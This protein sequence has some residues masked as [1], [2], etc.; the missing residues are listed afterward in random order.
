M[1]QYLSLNSLMEIL[2]KFFSQEKGV[3]FCYLF[4]SFAYKNFTSKSDIDIAV[5]LDKKKNR[6]FFEKRL[7]LIAELSKL[8]KREADVIILNN[9]RSI[10]LRYVIL[11]EGR[12]IFEKDR[13]KRIDFELKTLNEYFDFKPILKM[14]RQRMLKNI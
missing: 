14:Y 8:L 11:K 3:L 5:F 2:E 10:F 4:G 1:E 13:G 12:L 7:E 9:L 6:D